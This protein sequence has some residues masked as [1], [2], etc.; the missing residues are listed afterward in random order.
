MGNPY[1][2]NYHF[3][4]GPSDS[5]PLRPVAQSSPRNSEKCKPTVMQ[6]AVLII[7]PSILTELPGVCTIT[8]MSDQRPCPG[9]TMHIGAWSQ[10]LIKQWHLLIAISHH[11]Q[12]QQ[13][14]HLKNAQSKK[15]GTVDERICFKRMES[16]CRSSQGSPHSRM[17]SAS[18]RACTQ[19]PLL[20]AC[21]PRP[22]RPIG[23]PRRIRCCA[24]DW[25]RLLRD[26]IIRSNKNCF[27]SQQLAAGSIPASSDEQPTAAVCEC[28]PR[29][30]G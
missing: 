21:F 28:C 25:M 19:R 24:C 7:P 18:V 12:R 23:N 4:L 29:G 8:I 17:N 15:P 10:P 14:A 13:S 20:V 5:L 6:S 11:E 30:A 16:S 1:L 2:G 9:Q 3:R 26:V 27:S 22:S